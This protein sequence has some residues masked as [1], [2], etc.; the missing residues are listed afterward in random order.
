MEFYCSLCEY[1]SYFKVAVQRHITKQ[2]P[3]KFGTREI[4]EVPIDI[5]CDNCNKNFSTVSNLSEHKKFHCKNK[6]QLISE[7]DTVITELKEE[8]DVLRAYIEK[9]ILETEKKKV[10]ISDDK[11][12]LKDSNKRT[13][14]NAVLRQAVW[15]K[16]IGKKI[17]RMYR[18]SMLLYK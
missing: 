16:N 1:K 18:M 10:N 2:K 8:V 3:C 17:G 9:I 7:K 5:K 6:D 4:I 13:R 14:I 15:H 11:K 12:D